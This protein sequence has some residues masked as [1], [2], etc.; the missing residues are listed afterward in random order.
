MLTSFHIL[1]DGTLPIEYSQMKVF[2]ELDPKTNAITA[3]FVPLIL[4]LRYG[5]LWTGYNPVCSTMTHSIIYLYFPRDKIPPNWKYLRKLTDKLACK[6]EG[7]NED[8]WPVEYISCGS[9]N[10]ADHVWIKGT[11]TKLYRSS[12]RQLK[13]YKTSPISWNNNEEHE[14]Y[15]H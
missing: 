7:Y 11:I 5:R 6:E 12:T 1:N 15:Y 10:R 9:K 13:Q 3:S 4:R 2:Q 8:H 14:S